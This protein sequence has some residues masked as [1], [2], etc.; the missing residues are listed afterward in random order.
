MYDAWRR[1][2]GPQ[3]EARRL[4]MLLHRLDHLG[5]RSVDLDREP[6]ERD[7]PGDVAEVVEHSLDDDHLAFDGPLECLA[8]LHVVEH[9][10]NQLAAVADVLN[11]MRQI[12]DEAGSDAPEHRLAFLLP[13]V[14]LQ[15]DDAV[16][17]RVEGVAELFELVLAA[18]RDALVE[19][20]LGNRQR[21]A[22]EREDA[23]QE[24]PAP[25]R[26]DDDGA[27]KSGADDGEEL[28]LQARRD[29]ER[30]GLSAARPSTIQSR[31]GISAPTAS[32]CSPVS[33]SL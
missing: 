24:R 19:T 8:V 7:R 6:L 26:A 15:L 16:G 1:E 13:D 29:S 14:L 25:Q 3:R 11:R 30:L 33:S 28:P 18:H 17:H 21:R 20:A 4:R 31:L 2:L 5:E 9:L 10:L 23:G 12:V 32:S 22:P 27:E